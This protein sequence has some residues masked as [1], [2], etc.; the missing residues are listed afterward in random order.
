MPVTGGDA[1]GATGTDSEGDS[2]SVY[3]LYN[4]VFMR[5]WSYKRPTA[6]RILV[7]EKSQENGTISPQKAGMFYLEKER[8]GRI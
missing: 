8:N 2:V 3:K 4:A 6:K 1:E 7:V 5:L